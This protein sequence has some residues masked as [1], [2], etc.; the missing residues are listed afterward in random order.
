MINQRWPSQRGCCF[1]E[2]QPSTSS[3][4]AV[5]PLYG[6]CSQSR[7]WNTFHGAY[8]ELPDGS[9]HVLQYQTQEWLS[10][11]LSGHVRAVGRDK[12]SNPFI[13]PTDTGCS[14]SVKQ[15]QYTILFSKPSLPFRVVCP[16]RSNQPSV[17]YKFSGI[18]PVPGCFPVQWQLLIWILS[19]RV[20]DVE[21]LQTASPTQHSVMVLE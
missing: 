10:F 5:A 16:G 21:H 3:I 14:E 6:K 7:R 2:K 18:I 13:A 20:E 8:K 9:A 15:R 17:H 11:L 12:L 19:P 4:L 1:W